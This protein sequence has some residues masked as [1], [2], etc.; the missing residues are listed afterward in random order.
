MADDQKFTIYM[1]A[2]C[3]KVARIHSIKNDII[4]YEP[5]TSCG[6]PER[7][8]TE[9]AYGVYSDISDAISASIR[10]DAI[11]SKR[12]FE[13]EEAERKIR[14]IDQERKLLLLNLTQDA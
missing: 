12:Q 6:L 2:G 7:R 9:G 14:E 4:C 5:T 8:E 1:R 3:F 11:F 10:A 13:I